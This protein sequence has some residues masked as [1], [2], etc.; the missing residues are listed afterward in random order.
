ME[1]Q[2]PEL[3][4]IGSFEEMTLGSKYSDTADESSYRW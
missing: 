3:I 1:Y 2:V 4:E